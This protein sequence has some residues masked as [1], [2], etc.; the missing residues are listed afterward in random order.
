MGD[1]TIADCEDDSG[2]IRVFIIAL[3]IIVSL[4]DLR[5]VSIGRRR[6]GAVH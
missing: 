4:A 6:K 3:P 1:P 5:S 2:T